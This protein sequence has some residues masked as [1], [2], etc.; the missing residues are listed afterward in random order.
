VSAQFFYN[1]TDS[2]VLLDRDGRT[3]GGGEWGWAD[4]SDVQDAV[5][6]GRLVKAAK[7]GKGAR[8]EAADAYDRKPTRRG[9]SSDTEK[10]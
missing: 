4:P 1:P 5:D 10:E 3:L 2:P 6:S 7:P 8:P 9:D